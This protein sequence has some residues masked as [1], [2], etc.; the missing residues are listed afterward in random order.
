LPPGTSLHFRRAMALPDVLAGWGDILQNLQDANVQVAQLRLKRYEEGALRNRR[1]S[2]GRALTPEVL[3]QLLDALRQSVAWPVRPRLHSSP[4]QLAI[5]DSPPAPGGAYRWFWLDLPIDWL[6]ADGRP[7]SI[8][9]LPVARLMAPHNE[10]HH[11]LS[12][13]A[14]WHL[15]PQGSSVSYFFQQR[16]DTLWAF[17]GS[18][19]VVKDDLIPSRKSESMRAKRRREDSDDEEVPALPLEDEE[20]SKKPS[21]GMF[22]GTPMLLVGSLAWMVGVQKQSSDMQDALLRI[23]QHVCTIM[24]DEWICCGL[25]TTGHQVDSR[26]LAELLADMGV[27]E[28]WAAQDK[29]AKVRQ[30]RLP[31]HEGSK[32]DAH[33]VMWFAFRNAHRGPLV[34]QLARA[35]VHCTAKGLEVVLPDVLHANLPS[36]VL[37]SDCQENMQQ[38]RKALR[39]DDKTMLLY[40]QFLGRNMGASSPENQLLR[41][42]VFSSQFS[43]HTTMAVSSLAAA[44]LVKARGRMCLGILE[45]S[46]VNVAGDFLLFDA[47]RVSS[48]E[49]LLVHIFSSGVYV[50]APLQILPDQAAAHDPAA[51][52]GNLASVLSK[53]KRKRTRRRAGEATQSLMCAVAQAALTVLPVKSLSVWCPSNRGQAVEGGQRVRHDL[54]GQHFDWESEGKTAQWCLP[55]ELGPSALEKT[56]VRIL[57]LVADEGSTGWSM[58]Q[59]M[60]SWLKMR[61]FFIRDP[62]HRLSNMFTNAIGSVRPALAATLQTLVV[63]KFRRAPYGGGKHWKGLKETLS[64]FLREATGS[65]PMIDLFAEDICRDH[66][67]AWTQSPSQVLGLLGKMLEVPMGPKVEMRRW[68][69][70]WD[71]GWVLDKLWHSMLFSLVVWYGMNGEDAWEVCAQANPYQS[72]NSP[73]HC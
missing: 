67:Q 7:R 59:Y 58:Y 5:A 65:H 44:Y 31:D 47:S 21:F 1:V 33:W 17:L 45:A 25:P 71:A 68:F 14:L 23:L 26:A 41:E 24:P 50:C 70:Y 22:M 38:V 20:T 49:V 57:V 35:I 19:G 16:A 52:M 43:A 54:S 2:D 60:A 29:R 46:P 3:E 12:M 11:L 30:P 62:P 18:M 39:G 37:P 53:E 32:V 42:F 15:L 10:C 34:A 28:Q 9:P 63:H 27:L 8:F 64:V 61:V 40:N 48:K 66:R 6:E 56:H 4:L 55:D 36:C 51:A 13:T 69:T 72:N 73:Q